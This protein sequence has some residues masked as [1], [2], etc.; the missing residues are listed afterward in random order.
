MKFT[1]NLSRM[2][3][4]WVRVAAIVVSEMNERLS[5]KKAPPTTI[6]AM[7]ARFISVLSAMPATT[8]TNATMVP[9]EVPMESEMK[10]AARKMPA[11]SRW[12]G[13]RRSVRFTV[14]S[15][16]PISLALWA[17]APARMKIQ[18]ISMIFLLAAP[19]EYCSMRS[20][21]LSPLGMHTA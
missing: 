14:A 13:S 15:M 4:P 17:N 16:A 10:Q 8:G 7:K 18:I 19:M 20:F 21:R 3:H 12:S 9:T 1:R 6:P 11:S 2:A 5:P